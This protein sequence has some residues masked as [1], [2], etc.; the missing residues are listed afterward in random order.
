MTVAQAATFLK[1]QKPHL[2]GE[3][4]LRGYLAEDSC[5]INPSDL[6]LYLVKRSARVDIHQVPGAPARIPD[7]LY[8]ELEKQV[9]RL[10]GNQSIQ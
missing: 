8:A 2:L 9:E 3:G 10:N 5:R 1:V 6:V 7:E 4:R